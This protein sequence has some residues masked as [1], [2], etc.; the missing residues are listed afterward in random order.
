MGGDR[1]FYFHDTEKE[2]QYTV[3]MKKFGT[4]LLVLGLGVAIYLGYTQ[5]NQ[6]VKMVTLLKTASVLVLI[7]AVLFQVG[8][9][10]L[11]G[12]VFKYLLQ[13]FGKDAGILKLSRIAV[14]YTFITQMIPSAG[15]AAAPLFSAVK[16][17]KVSKAES[18][19]V[20]FLYFIFYYFTFFIA[21]FFGFV[22]LF[23]NHQLVRGEV[24]PVL[25]IV[26][27]IFVLVLFSYFLLRKRERAHAFFDFIFEK[28]LKKIPFIGKRIGGVHLKV[29]LFTDELYDAL[30]ILSKNKRKIFWPIVL[31]F[32]IHGFD[33]LTIYVLLQNFGYVS[34]ISVLIVGFCL[35][36]ILTMVSGVPL[37]IGVFE[38]SMALTYERLGVP[39]DSAFV[40]VFIFRALAFWFLLPIGAIVYHGLLHTWSLRTDE[41]N[42]IL[43]RSD[44][45]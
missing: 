26:S 30:E 5:W 32:L 39:F 2:L 6:L 1:Y 45:K 4:I 34:S 22:G 3:D 37:G 29:V 18:T 43:E 36:N 19:I 28:I 7:L 31:T 9:Y 21:L 24:E 17:T 13:I 15:V 8:T 12:I 41:K 23:F 33:L 44:K 40:S 11:Q 20:S 14:A 35:A 38:A 16:K 25:Y 42:A 27:V 10:V